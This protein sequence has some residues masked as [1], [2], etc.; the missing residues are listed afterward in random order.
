MH[1]QYRQI[2]S[3]FARASKVKSH[4]CPNKHVAHRFEGRIRLDR[5]DMHSKR[6]NTGEIFSPHP[7]DGKSLQ[8][9]HCR[10]H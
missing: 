7:K 5:E 8:I 6:G 9:F 1:Q 10:V 3:H 4:R 2:Q